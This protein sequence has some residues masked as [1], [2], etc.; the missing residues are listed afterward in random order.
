MSELI[1]KNVAEG[2]DG[3]VTS[4]T[5]FRA[6]EQGAER[7]QVTNLT[8]ESGGINSPNGSSNIIINAE[9]A[10]EEFLDKVIDY[11]DNKQ[12]MNLA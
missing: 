3:V 7:V 5:L 1:A 9:V 6:G 11:I 10:T 2:Y 4:P 8:K 12:S